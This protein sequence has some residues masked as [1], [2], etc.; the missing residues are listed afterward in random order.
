MKVII[1]KNLLLENIK[2]CS[3]ITESYKSSPVFLGMLIE[4]TNNEV[5]FT[6]TNGIFSVNSYLEKNENC[7]IL[8]TGIA[9]VKTKN[10]YSIISK[11][12]NEAITIE[13]I[14]NSILKIKTSNFDS[15]INLMDESI[16]PSIDFFSSG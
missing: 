16:F 12:N 1:N 9:F 3:S 4:V 11:L 15:N 13:K 7:L 14:D 10:F 2:I 8:E 5:K 6:S